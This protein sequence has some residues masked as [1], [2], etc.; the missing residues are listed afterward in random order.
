[1]IYS[2]YLI[3]GEL[4]RGQ[5]DESPILAPADERVLHVLADAS[6][7]QLDAAV[8]AAERAFTGWARTP[9]R[10]RAYLLLKLAERIEADAQ[11]LGTLES[12][13][14]GKPLQKAIGH[15]VP[16]VADVF[17]FFAGAARCLP[18]SAAGEYVAGSTSMIRRDPLGVVG[19][20]APWNYPLLM[21]AWKLAPALAA[22]NT[23]VFKPSELTPLSA[24]YLARLC[25]EIFPR[26][27]VNIL[28]GRGATLGAQLSAHPKVRMV[29]VTGDIAT[30]QAVV[31][32]A[33]GNLKR[34]HLEL[35]GKAPV[36]VFADADIPAAVRM[37]RT[38]GYYNA[39]QDCTAACRVY[40]AESVHE[41]FLEQ[42]AAEV[43]T[44]RTGH[45][46]DPASD[47]GPLI[48]RRQQERVQGFVERAAALAHS[49]VLVGGKV[50][51]GPGFFFQPT[52]IAGVR[53]DDEIVQ[54]EVFG[55]VVSVT[56]FDDEEQVLAWANESEYGLSA[57]VWTRDVK[58]AMRTASQLQ[59]GCVWVNQHMTLATEMP[60]G[61]LRQSGY[62]KDLSLYGLEDY[63]SVRH[64]MIDIG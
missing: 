54:K 14:C 48:S 63:T 4:V 24:L 50:V 36:L 60:H 56:A 7:A 47:F 40:V 17:R 9:P 15:E 44:L 27:V 33:A 21:A 42:L 5:G 35:G 25:V 45:P 22:G 8:D 34:T 41:Q 59:Y 19:L 61:G 58:K 31:R 23:V 57:S 2:E 30:G 51:D 38:G 46:E 62:G 10:Q 52:V 29:S 55:P 53:Q 37:M 26:G 12:Q 3:D 39:G 64:I 43:S 20:I 1:M 18:G 49:E 16:A 28:S 13:N 6:P 32:A 11:A